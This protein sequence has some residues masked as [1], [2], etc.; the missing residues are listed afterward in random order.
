MSTRKLSAQRRL[1]ETPR[2]V[3]RALFE[4]RERARKLAKPV[5]ASPESSRKPRVVS[6]EP[7]DESADLETRRES[8][9]G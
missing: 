9:G 4:S 1:Q 6:D 7:G 2:G 5:S 3:S 8:A